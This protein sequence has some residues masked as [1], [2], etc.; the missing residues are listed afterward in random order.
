M[1]NPYIEAWELRELVRKK[2]IRPREVADFFLARIEQLN[3][4]LG[5]FITVTPEQALADA[6]RLEKTSSAEAAALP[7]FG[8]PYS[9]KDL[10]WT[11]D[12]RTTFGSKNY[13]NW[14]APADAE[15]ATRL[16]N[17][18]GILLGKTSTPEFGS[19]PTTEGGLCPPA[20]NPWNLEHT[21]GGSSGGAGAAVASGMNP[22]AQGSDGG[23]SIRIPSACCG[24]VGLK[25]SRG[26]ITAAPAAGEGWGGFSTTGPMARTVRDAAM[27][28]DVMAGH[29]H[30][31][32]YAAFPN[33]RPF[34]ES[35]KTR[36][37][38]LKLAAISETALGPVD[39]E[40][41][42]AF[43]KACDAFAEM[44]HRVEVIKLD[45]GKLL[46]DHVRIVVMAGVGANRIENP[47]LMDP[48]V[49][50]TWEY[51]GKILAA[52]YIRA[53][54]QVHNIAREIV[55]R[56][57]PYD[58]LLTPTI[59]RPAVKLG[60]MA[61]RVETAGAEIYGWSAFVF[62]FNSTGQPA[63]TLPNGFT[64]DGLPIGVQ[65]V[66]RP[67][68]EA[69]VIALGAAFEEARPWKGKHPAL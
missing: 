6:A 48:L 43:D 61:T 36:P 19:R 39:P 42:A 1:I 4:K 53:L 9:L 50:S 13:E 37:K 54:A 29:S 32:P 34:L 46:I 69:G 5:A 51:G 41:R 3:A 52:D 11:K 64:K 62:P 15:L 38:D 30:G 35:I 60:T 44:G 57:M 2:E 67:Y 59:T 33:S 7:L 49:R 26:R 66:G 8:V 16:K 63:I 47:E 21:A 56:L 20:R 23:G 65:I 24:I 18:G 28:L 55:Q 31:D 27:M 10:T 40:T 17:S 14:R 58:A 25:P 22:I 12:I 68:D 45:P